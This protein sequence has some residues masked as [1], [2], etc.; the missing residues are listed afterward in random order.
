[1]DRAFR[2]DYLF[3]RLF[4][5]IQ[6][7]TGII[8][9]KVLTTTMLVDPSHQI[10]KLFKRYFIILIFV[11]FLHHFLYLFDLNVPCLQEIL[12]FLFIDSSGVSG[13]EHLEGSPEAI[14][15]QKVTSIDTCSHKLRISNEIISI[16]IYNIKYLQ[17]LLL[18]LVLTQ[19]LR[20]SLQ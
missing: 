11:H 5:S 2:I 4:W 8:M 20:Q 17:H 1:M 7:L 15:G 13:V 14:F 18:G 19:R 12:Q 10:F 6:I 3:R 16:R 9:I